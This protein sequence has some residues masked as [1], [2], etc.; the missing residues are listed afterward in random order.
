M[1]PPIP[2]DYVDYIKETGPF[3]CDTYDDAK[4]GYVV[5]WAFGEIAK[6]NSD[7]EIETYAPGFVAF[8]GNGGGELLVF[9]KTGAVFMLPMIG[10]A[11][12]CAIRIAENFQE[13]TTRMDFS[14]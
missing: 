1:L 10:M 9:D 11:P 6:S 4:P 12:D 3:E 7:L 8:G 2:N 13:L 5:L 14:D